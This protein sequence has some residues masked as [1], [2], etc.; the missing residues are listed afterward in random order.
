MHKQFIFYRMDWYFRVHTLQNNVPGSNLYRDAVMSCCVGTDKQMSQNLLMVVFVNIYIYKTWITR[1]VD[2][3]LQER[4]KK[5]NIK[6]TR[7]IWTLQA[8][9]GSTLALY[10]NPKIEKSYFL[11]FELSFHCHRSIAQVVCVFVFFLIY[12]KLHS[13]L[14]I[15]ADFL[16]YYKQQEDVEGA[17][18]AG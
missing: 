6:N 17:F 1:N 3:K 7:T 12:I 9:T 18:V 4:Y 13:L 11:K 8:N 16:L 2:R 5:Q 10:T 15:I 14:M